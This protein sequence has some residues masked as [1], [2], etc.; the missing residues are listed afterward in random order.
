MVKKFISIVLSVLTVIA[1]SGCNAVKQSNSERKIKVS[2]TFNAMAEF[3]RAVGKDKVDITTIIPDGTEPHDFE[4]KAKDIAGLAEANVFVYSGLGMESWVSKAVTSANNKNLITVEASKGAEPI[5]NSDSDKKSQYDPHIWLSI[6]GAQLEIKNIK[7]AL[8]KADPK[9]KDYFQKN[10][11]EFVSRLENL[12]SEY[13]VKFEPLN[14]KSFITGHAAFAYFCRDFGFKQNSVED[15]F[16]E[17]EPSAKKLAELVDY[18][19]K[20]NVKTV[21]VENMVSKSV[22]QTLAKQVGAK[23]ETIYTFESS[24]DNLSYYDRMQK[25]LEKIYQSIK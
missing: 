20:N 2:V 1:L 18:C 19:R 13:S 16:A 5:A 12:Y 15:V 7:D 9:D 14:N 10:C 17:G 22:S 24:E 21:F 11:N 23:V 3:V 25:N 8:I 4:P 6:K